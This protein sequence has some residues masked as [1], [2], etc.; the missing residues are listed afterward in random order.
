MHH[1]MASSTTAG[2]VV[3]PYRK[4]RT[5][6]DWFELSA[7][8]AGC[9]VLV[10]RIW[11]HGIQDVW[12]LSLIVF[13]VLLVQSLTSKPKLEVRELEFQHLTRA[14]MP[15]L[16]RFDAVGEII[17]TSFNLLIVHQTTKGWIRLEFTKSDFCQKCWPRIVRLLKERTRTHSPTASIIDFIT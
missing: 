6:L 13:I 15:E 1:H 4:H 17:E 7:L 3:F 10:A 14:K 9:M 2:S 11:M 8:A 5:V 16:V 12:D